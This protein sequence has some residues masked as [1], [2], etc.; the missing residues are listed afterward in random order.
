MGA[1][2]PGTFENDDAVSWL[3]S[4]GVLDLSDVAQALTAV[5]AAES[6]EAP[7]ASIALAAAEL[8]A[9]VG[10]HPAPN[11]PEDATR[12]VAGT[13]EPP[14]QALRELAASAVGRVVAN[15]ELRDLW[16]E[17]ADLERWEAIVADLEGRLKKTG[18]REAAGRAQQRKAPASRRPRVREGDLLWVPVVEGKFAVGIVMHVSRYF[19]DTILVGFFDALYSRPEE[20]DV[21]SLAE[22]F[23]ETPNYVSTH[24]VA[25]GRWSVIGNSPEVL[26][27]CAVPVLRV[28]GTL[29]KKDEIVGQVAQAEWPK[30][31]GLLGQTDK[32][33]EI[34]LRRHF[35]QTDQ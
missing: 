18:A 21:P 25:K 31:P 33:V 2:G 1:W 29:Y 24:A 35:V 5:E 20:V 14:S 34:K 3:G 32:S 26:A 27:R 10:G 6:V 7:E 17:S 28:V 16:E 4:V 9:A 12:L 22:P 13:R 19:H 8:V 23:V 30:Y 11:L 15:S